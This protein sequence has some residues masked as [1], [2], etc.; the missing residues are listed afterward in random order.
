MI[1][2]TAHEREQTLRMGVLTLA[3]AFS[4]PMA[5]RIAFCVTMLYLSGT[6]PRVKKWPIWTFIV[7]QLIVNVGTVI[8]FYA[9]CGTHLDVFWNPSKE[10]L[11]Q[12]YCWAAEYQ[13]DFGYFQGSFNT[14]TDAFLTALPAILIEH[15]SLSLKKKIGL[16]FLLCL[17]ILALAA[18]IVKTYEAKALSEVIDFTCASTRTT[19]CFLN[20]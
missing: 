3:W 7:L 15:T 1:Y 20:D 12:K 5:G 13:T 17:S 6:D 10:A 4:S 18:S 9:Q 2:L 16:A 19:I 8:V 14:L 11:S